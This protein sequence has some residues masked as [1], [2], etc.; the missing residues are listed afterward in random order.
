MTRAQRQGCVGVALIVA[1][2]A[3]IALL[4]TGCAKARPHEPVS[5]C[6]TTACGDVC[7]NDDGRVCPPCWKE[8]R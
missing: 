7:C 2:L 6:A 4:L 1:G 3:V 5:P 8:L